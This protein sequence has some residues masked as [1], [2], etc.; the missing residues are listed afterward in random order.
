MKLA[1]IKHTIAIP[2]SLTYG[3]RSI[4]KRF[5]AQEKSSEWGIGHVAKMRSRIIQAGV[6]IILVAVCYLPSLNAGY[7]WDDD[8]YVTE[9]AALRSADGLIQIWFEPQ[10]TPQ[11]YPLVFTS[12][13]IEY[14]VWKLRPMGYHGVNIIFHCL[15]T[16]L[17][18]LILDALLIPGAWFAAAVFGLHPVHVESVAWITER[19]NL[20]SGL[21]Y[22]LAV[23][24]Y[25][26][27]SFGKSLQS[28]QEPRDSTAEY[29]SARFYFMS[30][31]FFILALF[32]KTVTSTMPAVLAL[33]LWWKKGTLRKRD[34]VLLMPFFFIGA[35]MGLL[36]AWWEKVHV[37]AQGDH[38][39]FS[40]IERF[41]IAG[42]A[43]W[44]YV[45]KIT[46][47]TDLVFNYPRWEISTTVWWQYL[48]PLGAIT[49]LIVMWLW[50]LRLGRGLFVAT[51]CFGITLFP[52]LGFFNVFPM[53]YSFVADHF[54]YLASI[55]PMVIFTQM[56]KT[57]SR[58][59][60]IVAVLLLGILGVLTWRQQGPYA[61]E[62][63]LWNDTL[64]HNPSSWMAYINLGSIY[65]KRQQ[66]DKAIACFQK[67]IELHPQHAEASY[68]LGIA[69][70]SKGEI[71]NAISLFEEALRLNPN[72]SEAYNNLGSVWYLKKDFDKSISC[73]QKSLRINPSN[74]QA[75]NN[76]GV[77]LA[78]TGRREEAID[79]FRAALKIQPSYLRALRGLEKQLAAKTTP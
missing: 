28:T 68:N 43:A 45:G 9:N 23:F 6:L 35:G 59:R 65:L 64:K 14:H 41:L 38:W 71:D 79:H 13:W 42:R 53:R 20:L 17:L 18:W 57:S 12:F 74:A 76:L 77:A 72:Y 39:S 5:P 19:K 69:L 54:Q 78:D 10:A 40:V 66:I 1:N 75:H 22:L 30:L 52:A 46:L 31:V 3:L 58:Q 56:W 61:N 8:F 2:W 24:S 73:F 27:F 44:F 55:G 50:R 36:T 4:Y 16:V 67:A 26:R 11:Y 29:L 48:F 15:N 51:M 21:C 7:I 62:E 60:T 49:A 47:P 32:S 33:I 37:G 25:L 70:V 63:S 34:I